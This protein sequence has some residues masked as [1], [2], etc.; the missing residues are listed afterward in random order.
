MDTPKA[1]LL[2]EV[3]RE[4]AEGLLK[5]EQF[6][7]QKKVDGHRRMFE[8]LEDGSIVSYGRDGKP[9]L[10]ST[11]K[12]VIDAVASLPW[13]TF[14]VDGEM[15]PVVNEYHAFDLLM[16]DGVNLMPE[17]FSRRWTEL[18]ALEETAKLKLVPTFLVTKA[19]QGAMAQYVADRAEGVVFRRATAPYR[20]G[21]CDQHFKY[22]FTKTASVIVT[23][24]GSGGRMNCDMAVA[25]MEANPPKLVPVGSC[26]TI[27]KGVINPGD[28]LEVRFLYATAANVLYQPR[29]LQKRIDLEPADCT[30]KQLKIAYKE[31]I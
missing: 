17:P 30:L 29:I 21:R 1:E 10:N 2:T 16:A 27:G 28:I 8:R 20:S 4:V 19:K 25:D 13:K 12:E 9:A 7:L 26:T 14:L 15:I 24:V 5:N 23:A 6:W 31:G 18:V 3:T 22:K 11:P